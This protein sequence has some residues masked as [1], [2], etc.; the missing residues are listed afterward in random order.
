MKRMAAV[1]LMLV[2]VM[3]L[4]A[5]A[6]RASSHGGFSGHGSSVFHGSGFHG[7]APGRS[8]NPTRFSVNRPSNGPYGYQ[9][10]GPGNSSSRQ[11]YTDP[12][13]RRTPYHPP[14]RRE[15]YGNR[16]WAGYPGWNGWISPYLLGYPDSDSSDDSSQ[17]YPDYAADGYGGQSPNQ[18]G[19]PG[20]AEPRLP[21][22][23][24]VN[25]PE[26]SPAPAHEDAVTLVF[27]DGRPAEQIHNYLLTSTTLSVLDQH[28]RDIP[29]DQ[30]D[31][32]A[33]AKVN[34]DAGVDFF[35]PSGT[36]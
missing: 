12:M 29:V 14:N 25:F 32:S 24:S 5:C 17:P 6:Q 18:P 21:S 28:R 30:I 10:S 20:E 35:V 22:P 33:T 1:V 15:G 13:H 34:H 8:A 31:L 2:W 9:R 16:G 19:E 7:S 27:K 3:G 26:P 4:P 23:P 36:R 11:P